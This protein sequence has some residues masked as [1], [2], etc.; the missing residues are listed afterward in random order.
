M[1]MFALSTAALLFAATAF[2][3]PHPTQEVAR[4]QHLTLVR[5]S[6]LLLPLLLR[7]RLELRVLPRL[8]VR[9]TFLCNGTV[10]PKVTEG[11]RKRFRESPTNL[12]NCLK[13]P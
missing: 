12:K 3:A 6:L 10:A 7:S 1:K 4:R 8:S 11:Q 5:Y 13:L 2:R 9:L